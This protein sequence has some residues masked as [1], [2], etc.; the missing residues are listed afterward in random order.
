MDR[1]EGDLVVV[2]ADGGRRLD[3]PRWLFPDALAEGDVVAVR[4]EGE[5][6]LARV[7]LRLD[8]AA[9]AAARAEAAALLG[10]LRRSEPGGGRAP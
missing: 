1:L 7:E 4:R 8:R 10:R 9:T 5:G 2:R 3:L 6:E